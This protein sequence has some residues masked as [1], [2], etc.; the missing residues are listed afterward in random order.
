MNFTETNLKN[1][2]NHI[3]WKWAVASNKWDYDWGIWVV[4]RALY[5]DTFDA[6]GRSDHR[7]VS[8]LYSLACTKIA[9]RYKTTRIIDA[10]VPADYAPR[11]SEWDNQPTGSRLSSTNTHPNSDQGDQN[12]EAI[13][14]ITAIT[15]QKD[16]SA[17]T[18]SVLQALHQISIRSFN[19]FT[20]TK[21]RQGRDV[22]FTFRMK[23]PA[24]FDSAPAQ[25][26]NP[27]DTTIEPPTQTQPAFDATP[28]D[29]LFG[30]RNWAIDQPWIP[31]RGTVPRPDQNRVGSATS[32][33]PFAPSTTSHQPD[34]SKTCSS[35]NQ[36][37]SSST[38]PLQRGNTNTGDRNLPSSSAQSLNTT[39]YE[40]RLDAAKKDITRNLDATISKCLDS[41]RN[42]LRELIEQKTTELEARI[43][44]AEK[45]WDETKK[46]WEQSIEKRLELSDTSMHKN[47]LNLFNEFKANLRPWINREIERASQQSQDRFKTDLGPLIRDEVTKEVSRQLQ[48]ERKKKIDR[49]KRK[50]EEL[51]MDEMTSPG[52]N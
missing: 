8:F 34:K 12:A 50:L 36:C 15:D 16:T 51:E 4:L 32:N 19:Q 1:A 41:S 7:K 24:S 40:Q 20:P 21:A 3:L 25:H 6:T 22:S 38:S 46:L 27:K 30:E 44:T 37:E 39:T 2:S 49:K 9:A 35:F 13:P 10:D 31:R 42:E 45:L 17:A 14:S 43:P 26:S 48:S 52:D 18:Q 28:S 11:P 33:D 47:T 23:L 29:S 5:Y